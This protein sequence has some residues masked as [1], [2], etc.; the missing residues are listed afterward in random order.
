MQEFVVFEIAGIDFIDL[1]RLHHLREGRYDKKHQTYLV[2]A[3]DGD[4]AR[5][6]SLNRFLMMPTA[7]RMAFGISSIWRLRD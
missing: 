3:D 2:E 1:E 5:K 6:K 4:S 7:A